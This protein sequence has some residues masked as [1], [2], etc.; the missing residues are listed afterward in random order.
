MIWIGME[1]IPL[2]RLIGEIVTPIGFVAAGSPAG[3]FYV[4][5]LDSHALIRC[6]PRHVYER[7]CCLTRDGR[8]VYTSRPTASDL[9]LNRYARRYITMAL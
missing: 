9:E 6:F 1:R 2:F 3:T 7:L 4:C 8:E 5:T